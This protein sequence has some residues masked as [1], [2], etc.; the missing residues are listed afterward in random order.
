MK[1][2]Q[3]NKKP[4]SSKLKPTIKPPLFNG[5]KIAE[6]AFD[7]GSATVSKGKLGETDCYM[8]KL[9]NDKTGTE[10]KVGLS[11]QAFQSLVFI[12]NHVLS[13]VEQIQIKKSET[14]KQVHECDNVYLGNGMCMCWKCGK[15]TP[16]KQ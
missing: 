6:S 2:Q 8:V 1:K 15:E 7:G 4:T 10:T 13:F 12:G 16:L 9:K 3:S 5:F 14:K 11:D